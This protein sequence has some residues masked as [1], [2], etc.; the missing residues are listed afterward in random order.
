MM[1][2]EPTVNCNFQSTFKCGYKS[3]VLGSLHW[4]RTNSANLINPATGPYYDS[5]GTKTGKLMLYVCI[6]CPIN[7]G[8]T[9]KS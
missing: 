7:T 1:R 6:V 3:T 2:L 9:V 4:S 5:K 8:L